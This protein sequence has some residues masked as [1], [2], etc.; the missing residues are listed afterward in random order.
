MIKSDFKIEGYNISE[1]RIITINKDDKRLDFEVGFDFIPTK[2]WVDRQFNNPELS[3]CFNWLEKKGFFLNGDRWDILKDNSSKHNHH[4]RLPQYFMDYENS[5]LRVSFGRVEA[6]SFYY[7]RPNRGYCSLKEFPLYLPDNC[8]IVMNNSTYNDKNMGWIDFTV[9]DAFSEY[10]KLKRNGS[11][12]DSF[13]FKICFDRL[14]DFEDLE[15]SLIP[16]DSNERTR[17]VNNGQSIK[18]FFEIEE[19]ILVKNKDFYN[20]KKSLESV[21]KFNL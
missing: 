13:Y 11:D 20:L 12:I 18:T 10:L 2:E 21:S 6:K 15:K 16:L 19:T 14:K 3:K 7:P 1:K 17:I 5:K 8:Y 4:I 9:Q